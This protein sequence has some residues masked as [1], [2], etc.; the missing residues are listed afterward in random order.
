MNELVSKM[1]A[2]EAEV[3]QERGEI[4]FFALL[5]AADLP[6]QWDV[7]I[8]APWVTENKLRDLKYLA[9]KLRARLDPGELLSLAR[10]VL[11]DPDESTLSSI[12]GLLNVKPGE[13]QLVNVQINDLQITHAYIITADAAAFQKAAAARSAPHAPAEAILSRQ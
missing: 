3:A 13:L 6:H 8:A 10:I 4:L 5:Q 7:V 2:V 9:E 12:D 1:Q 11:L